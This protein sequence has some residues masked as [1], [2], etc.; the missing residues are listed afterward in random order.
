MTR[1]KSGK[2][3]WSGVE[4]ECVISS[5]VTPLYLSVFGT[6][7]MSSFH[8]S[9][10]NI[11]ECV[12]ASVLEPTCLSQAGVFGLYLRKGRITLPGTLSEYCAYVCL[13]EKNQLPVL[14]NLRYYL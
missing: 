7:L 5:V 10:Q 1:V 11:V 8:L 13:T 12:C 4:R 3:S 9:L 2:S 14:V 6:S